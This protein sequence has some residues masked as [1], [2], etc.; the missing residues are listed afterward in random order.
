[1]HGTGS[2]PPVPTIART[3]GNIII[4]NRALHGS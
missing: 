4:D 1:M 2:G 3:D